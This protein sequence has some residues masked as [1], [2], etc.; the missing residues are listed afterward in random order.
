MSLPID[1]IDTF[2]LKNIIVKDGQNHPLDKN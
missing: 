2:N 1:D